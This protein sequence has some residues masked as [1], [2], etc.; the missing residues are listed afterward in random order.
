MKSTSLATAI[1]LIA[2]AVIS[3]LLIYLQMLAIRSAC[4]ETGAA[5]D[6]KADDT[7]AFLKKRSRWQRPS[8]KSVY[9]PLGDV[10]DLAARLNWRIFR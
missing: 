4:A 7:Q 6:G 3:H 1:F 8:R 10:S 5:G 2:T 9:V